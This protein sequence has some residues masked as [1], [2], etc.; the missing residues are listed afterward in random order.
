MGAA[1]LPKQRNNEA[2]PTHLLRCVSLREQEKSGRFDACWL[3]LFCPCRA[4]VAAS[5]I[6]DMELREEWQDDGF[7]RWVH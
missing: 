6:Q 5:N 3:N 7:P 2:P 4:P 1:V